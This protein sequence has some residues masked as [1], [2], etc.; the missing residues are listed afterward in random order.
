M[1][2][3]PIPTEGCG[4]CEH[5]HKSDLAGWGLCYGPGQAHF[6]ASPAPANEKAPTCEKFRPRNV[7]RVSTCP[8]R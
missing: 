7:Q 8:P 5:W 4:R 6:Y 3:V 2:T 1:M